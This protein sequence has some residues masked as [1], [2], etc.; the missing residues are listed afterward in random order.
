MSII[1]TRD[2]NGNPPVIE[3]KISGELSVR[4]FQILVL[5]GMNT[6]DQAHA[7]L[8][9]AVDCI[10]HGVPQ[11][12]YFTLQN[13]KPRGD[14]ICTA[15]K[16]D[17]LEQSLIPTPL[18][19]EVQAIKDYW[20]IESDATLMEVFVRNVE[21][22]KNRALRAEERLMQMMLREVE[23]KFGPRISEDQP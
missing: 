18:E 2:F 3:I 21:G 15:I 1:V 5:R 17:S 7:E 6:N 12:D 22:W 16:T 10:V 23:R 19:A 4:D 20:A 14:A 13:Q 11:Q 8:K 9:W